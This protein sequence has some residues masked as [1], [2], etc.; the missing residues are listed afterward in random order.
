MSYRR[1]QTL[2]FAALLATLTAIHC[3][4]T[5]AQADRRRR[6]T[7]HGSDRGRL[8]VACDMRSDTCSDGRKITTQRATPVPCETSPGVWEMVPEDT[9]CYSVRGLESWAQNTSY[10]SY[11]AE[12]DRSPWGG[13]ATATK[14]GANYRVC[15]ETG[16]RFRQQLA[17]EAGGVVRTAACRVRA[18]TSNS[19]RLLAADVSSGGVSYDYTLTSE[20]QTVTATATIVADGGIAGVRIHPARAGAGCIDVAGCWS[21]RGDIPGRPCWGGE[22]PVTCAADRHTISTEGWPSGDGEISVVFTEDVTADAD[23]VRIIL[24]S[25]PGGTIGFS[26]RVTTEGDLGV[27]SGGSFV[28]GPALTPGVPYH[29]RFTRTGSTLT[30]YLNGVKVLERELPP[31][32]WDTTATLGRHP[33]GSNIFNG[34][35]SSLR[36]RSFE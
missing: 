30:V 25:R 29:A 3:I 14:D 34:S 19:I 33:T 4:P 17:S 10:L 24:D 2:G 32:E 5:E 28:R 26:V 21:V 18:G 31:W 9:G 27:T 6:W 1:L 15:G 8:V 11:G 36:V 20:W 22:A 13:L 16:E 7:T 12:L 23:A 35:I